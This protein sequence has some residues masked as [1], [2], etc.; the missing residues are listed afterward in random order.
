MNKK[1]IS[2]ISVLVAGALFGAILLPLSMAI[3]QPPHVFYGI[4]TDGVHQGA[5]GTTAID[6]EITGWIDGVQYGIATVDTVL[7]QFSLE[8][9]GDI[10]DDPISDPVKEGGY[11]GDDVMFF[12]EYNPMYYTFNISDTT[13]TWIN[14]TTEATD[15]F[16]DTET[17]ID[18]NYLGPGGTFLR[19]LKIN[20]IVLDPNDDFPDDQYLYLYDF[21]GD[22]DETR[23]EDSIHGYYLQKDNEGA[24]TTDGPIFDFSL[25][26][27]KVVDVG[28]G[29]YYIN[30]TGFELNTSDELKLVWKNPANWGGTPTAHNIANGSDVIVDRVE[31][32]N[33]QNQMGAGEP[34]AWRDYDNTSMWDCPGALAAGE[35]YIRTTNGTDSDNCSEDFTVA[36]ATPRYTPTIILTID[37]IFISLSPTGPDWIGDQ[38]Y[39]KYETATFYCIGWNDT[40]NQF[41]GLVVADWSSNNPGVGDVNPPTTGSSVI[42]EAFSPGTCIV[43]VTY[44][45]GN[46]TGTLT[47]P[48]ETIDIVFISLSD[49]GSTGWIGDQ[50]YSPSDTDIFYCVGWNTTYD[51]FVNLVAGGWSSDTPGV[52]SVVPGPDT[53]TT[54]TANSAGQCIVSVTTAEGDN[55]TG[56]IT[57]VPLTTD[58]IFISLTSDG[59]TG[60]IGD[61]SYID[62]DT[63]TYYCVGWNDTYNTFVELVEV[64]WECDNPAVGS[65]VPGPASSTTFTTV[66]IGT[67]KVNATHAMYTDNQTGV[68]TVSGIVGGPVGSP[69]DLEVHK[70][71]G[72]WGGTTDDLVLTWTTPSDDYV[73]LTWNIVYMDMDLSD[74]FQYTYYWYCAP[75]NTGPGTED[76]CILTGLLTNTNNYVFRVNTTNDLSSQEG[77]IFEN[78]VGTNVGYKYIM[79]LQENPVLTSQLVVSIPYYC[80]WKKGEDIAGMGKEFDDGS[81]IA[82]LSVWNYTK[83]TYDSRRWN[84]LDG[85]WLENITI[86]PGDALVV[87]VTAPTPYQWNIVGAYDEGFTFELLVNPGTSQMFLSLPYHKS[88]EKGEDICGVGTEFPD[89]QVVGIV[90]QWNYSKQTYDSRRWN[91]L[92]GKWLENFTIFASPGDHLVIFITKE[93]PPY[94]WKPQVKDF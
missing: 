17:D 64:D 1:R 82:I 58:R 79:W 6:S 42:F 75:N 50:F 46:D 84:P 28:G 66:G 37:K 69:S 23:L 41:A 14:K 24:H 73:N 55:D 60:W 2:I 38:T 39:L 19:A 35:S 49:D 53:S 90:S 25:N 45:G 59:S 31:W 8:V 34:P 51:E 68:L 44:D 67:C 32:G 70:G 10:Y 80:D 33:F 5:A 85:K 93:L 29:S 30:L 52:G 47:I 40:Y 4:A 76:S 54:F 94:Y 77:G 27:E 15:L 26:T 48:T 20:E 72:A 91:P 21:G 71:G 36:T 87:S 9:M 78:M 11:D 83:Q 61:Q 12:L 63:D 7:G 57:V 22:L 65:V 92:D 74:G 89:D 16:F 18:D 43:S 3:P 62:P 88:Y 86:N 81:K 56:V 13:K